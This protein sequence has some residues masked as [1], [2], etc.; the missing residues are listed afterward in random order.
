ML[1]LADNPPIT[2]SAEADC[3]LAELDWDKTWRVAY[4]K[5]RQEKS[6]AK[7]LIE[8]R[9]SY[10]LPMVL[11]ETSSGG[12][13]RQNMY[14]LFPSYLFFGGDEFARLAC[15]RTERT[16]QLIEPD[17]ENQRRMREELRSLA[18]VINNKPDDVELYNSLQPGSH[19][20]VKSGPMRDVEGTILKSDSATKLQLAV[21]LLG[22][23]VMVEIHPDLVEVF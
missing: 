23:G 18:L 5:P 2:Y 13:R 19:V 1:K 16:V 12:R 21:T 17:G 6:L 14:P 15:L 11:R 22:V 9:V 4:V 10:F 3:G 7:D 20:R 8:R